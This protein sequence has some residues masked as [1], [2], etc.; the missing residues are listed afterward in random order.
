MS[1]T[2]GRRAA[3]SV[4]RGSDT[5]TKMLLSENLVRLSN[6]LDLQMF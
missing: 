2:E 4:R 1:G 3:S 5:H 6:F